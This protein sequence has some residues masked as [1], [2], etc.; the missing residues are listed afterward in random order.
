MPYKR[1]KKWVGEVMRGGSEE[2]QE[3]PEQRRNA[4][5]GVRTKTSVC[6]QAKVDKFF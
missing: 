6:L 4:T 2:I 5:L 1:G 3:I